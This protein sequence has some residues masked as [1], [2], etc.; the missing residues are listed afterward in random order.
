MTTTQTASKAASAAGAG[1]DVE[2]VRRDFPILGRTL[3]G[4][5]PLAYLDNAATTQKPA[6]V[7]EAVG[8]Y[9]ATCNANVHRALH[10]L[11]EEATAQ[12]EGTR[13]KVAALI[14]APAARS[15]VFTRGTTEGINL[16]AHAWGNRSL[17]QGDEIVLTEM[18]HHSNLIPWQL[19]AR[20]TGAVLRH[21]PVRDDGTLD[22]E[23]YRE[24]LSPRTKLVAVTHMSNVLGTINPVKKMIQDAHR[25]GAR[26]LVDG[27]QSVPHLAVDVQD[28]DCDFL[29]FSA[30]KMAGPTGIGILW[31]REELLEV[32][33]PFLG[34]GEMILKVTL[35]EATWAEIPQKFEAGTPNVAGVVGLAAALDYLAGLGHDA[36]ADHERKMDVYLRERLAGVPGLKMFGT[37]PDRGGVA[38][39][40]LEGVHP[41]DIAQFVDR[42]GVAIRAGHMC[43]QPLMRRY[44]VPALSR[45]SLYFYNN[46]SDIDQLAAA[47]DKV[48]E[49]FA[50]GA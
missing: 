24:L 30:H 33:D 48:R 39:F 9:Y 12:Y 34:G 20:R 46:T 14:N 43:A 41:H 27:A 2:R 28:L 49:F 38:S 42:D 16:V 25:V 15:V 19:L 1:L 37:G 44:G 18:E 3:R 36:V 8:A 23:R 7:I 50:H 6:A 47:L 22:L 40:A 5:R 31:G 32:M 17:S 29:A 10:Q 13:G 11:A 26:V 35:E 45:A 21:V 4:N